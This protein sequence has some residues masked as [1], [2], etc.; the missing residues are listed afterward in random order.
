MLLAE[1]AGHEFMK[2]LLDNGAK[3]QQDEVYQFPLTSVL[4][5]TLISVD[6]RSRYLKL[7][8]SC[9]P[10]SS[11]FSMRKQEEA[12]QKVLQTSKQQLLFKIRIL[13]NHILENEERY[14][15]LDSMIEPLKKMLRGVELEI[16]ALQKSESDTKAS[17]GGKRRKQKN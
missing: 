5:Y 7:N 3:L 16:K 17:A 10:L 1:R 12:M 14:N 15:L 13:L 2:V 6:R 8:L 4:V 9:T 11:K